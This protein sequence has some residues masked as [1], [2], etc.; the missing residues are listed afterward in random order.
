METLCPFSL[1]PSL[2]PCSDLPVTPAALL[3]VGK[4]ACPFSKPLAG[5]GSCLQDPVVPEPASCWWVCPL[6]GRDA[7]LTDT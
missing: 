5:A 4:A 2:L 1:L 3:S 7:S 6:C